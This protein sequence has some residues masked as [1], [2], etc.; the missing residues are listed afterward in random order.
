MVNDTVHYESHKLYE[1]YYRIYLKLFKD[2]QIVKDV[3]FFTH[4][5]LN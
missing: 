3:N 2:S 4:N 5:F 1:I